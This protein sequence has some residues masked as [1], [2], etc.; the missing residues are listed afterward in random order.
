MQKISRIY[1]GSYG[2]DMAWYDG[3][4]FDLTDPATGEPTD[5]ILNLENGG[6]KTTLLSF[7]FSCF[8][9]PQE[10]F[11]KHIQNKNHRFSQY[12]ARDGQPGVILIEWVM[13]PRIAGGQPYRLVLGQAVAVKAGAERD[14]VERLFFSFE[15]NSALNFESVPAPKLNFAPVGSMLELSRWIHDAHKLAPDFFQTKVQQDWQKHLREERLIDV[16][17]LKLQ[18]NFS[19]EEGGIDSGFLTFNSEPEFIRKFF[20]LTLDEG[21]AASVR[22]SVVD[23]CDKLRRKPHLQRCLTEL[24]RLRTSLLTFNDFAV[25]YNASRSAQDAVLRRGAGLARGLE[26]MALGLR[27]EE[28]VAAANEASQTLLAKNKELLAKRHAGEATTLRLLQLTRALEKASE[29][30]ES[31]QRGVD[32]ARTTQQCVRAAKT[33]GEIAAL[34]ARLEEL[35]ASSAAAREALEPWR[36]KAETQGAL[37]RHALRSAEQA[38]RDQMSAAG[39]EESEAGQRLGTLVQRLRELEAAV[40]KLD[41]EEARLNAAEDAY[42]TALAQLIEEGVLDEGEAPSAALSRYADLASEKRSEEQQRRTQAATFRGQER[43]ARQH[44]KQ[45]ELD[46][47][48]AAGS[49]AQHEAFVADGEVEREKLS[50]LPILRLVAEADTADPESPALLP[51]LE[52]LML[53]EERSV[54]QHAVQLSTLEA[55]RSAIMETGVAGGSRDVDEV[56][57]SLRGLGVK[58]AKPF[59]T[60]LAQAIPDAA[61][62]RTLVLSNPARFLGVSVASSE[63]TRARE[64][65][66]QALPLDAPVMVSVAALEPEVAGEDRFVLPAADDAAFNQEAAQVLLRQLDAKLAIAERQRNAHALRHKEAVTAQEQ[67]LA[68]AKRFGGGALA[69]A[70]AETERLRAESAAALARAKTFEAQAEEYD[71][72]AEAATDAAAGCARAAQT[73]EMHLSAVRSFSRTHD[74]DRPTRLARLQAISNERA[75]QDAQRAQLEAEQT[76]LAAAKERAFQRKVELDAKAGELLKERLSVTYR[77]EG[78]PAEEWL[79]AKPQTLEVL[80]VLYAD[81]ERTYLTEASQRLGLLSLEEEQARKGLTEREQAFAV[82]FEEV[83]PEDYESYLA[84][85][86]FP[87]QLRQCADTLAQAEHVLKGAERDETEAAT[88]RKV[89]Q[90]DNRQVEPASALMLALNDA[91]LEETL[92]RTLLVQQEAS[93]AAQ[94]A[95]AAALRHKSA[96]RDAG[97]K[98]SSAEQSAGTLRASLGLPDLLDA[99][100]ETPESAFALQARALIAEF[101]RKRND[102]EAAR[103]DA[104]KAFERL[105][106]EAATPAMQEV[107]PDIASQLLR[108]E[109]E[110]A[111]A[112]SAR[113]LEG[114]DDRI[115]TTQSS[116]DGMREDFD[117]CLGELHNLAGSAITLLNSACTNKR[118]PAGAPYVG[119]KPILKMRARF[120]ELG[121]DVRRQQLGNYLDDLIESKTV[122]VKGADLVA[123]ALLRI[124]GKPLGLQMLKMVPDEALQYVAVDKIQNSGGEGVVMAMFLYMLTNQLRAETQAKLKKAGGGPLI[125]DNPFAKATTPTLWKAQ[126]LLAQAMDVQLIFA[127]ALPDYNTVGEFGRFVRLRKAGKNTKTGRWHIEAVDFKLNEE[128]PVAEVAR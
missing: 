86:D 20:G 119:G 30:K 98:A 2:A 12:F 51:A 83:C 95:L 88:E 38:L 78:F 37:L 9:T 59:N 32:A 118:V 103:K 96:A 121:H 50:Q 48:T 39:T 34:E 77:R 114:L 19:A 93:A 81:A 84:V 64:L 18:V 91:A 71:Q 73:A 75:E 102:S 16:D 122:P 82:E 126:R 24:T 29:R 47:A 42:L 115:G 101:N 55:S 36:D 17:M 8:D 90:K 1:V 107:E 117:A 52:R 60:Y 111:C 108:N 100:P 124:H 63:L 123:D 49:I 41:A 56:V 106:A 127:T 92:S 44:A 28:E 3:V 23:V 54:A 5:T 116:L 113:L 97:D 80:R 79:Q 61:A 87:A 33:R 43:D 10:R 94:T 109:F 14:E 11:L 25:A 89:F 40:R 67:L 35:V 7:V 6:G 58:S 27:E 66:G 13:P 112:D 22:Q 21:L 57:A 31:A 15:A 70:Q 62:A 68:Y 110:E 69:R 45:A 104:T 120:N 125:L 26:A 128:R 85:Q 65:L 53:A 99:E 72:H 46:A 105:K 74:A 76:A 4:T